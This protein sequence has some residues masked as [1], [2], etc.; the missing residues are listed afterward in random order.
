MTNTELLL[1]SGVLAVLILWN[2]FAGLCLTISSV[3]IVESLPAV[4]LPSSFTSLLGL[5][6]LLSC[7]GGALV[8]RWAFFLPRDRT[9]AWILAFGAAS[10]A[11]LAL[12]AK[13]NPLQP[14]YTYAQMV[15]LVWLTG[16]LADTRRRIEV[17]MIVWILTLVVTQ[18]IGLAGFDF[19]VLGRGNRLAS[20][21]HNPNELAFYSITGLCFVLYFLL[22][23]RGTLSRALLIAAF[24]LGLLSVLLSASRGGFLVLVTVM[25]FALL[26]L[27]SELARGLRIGGALLLF[28]AAFLLASNLNL[29]FVSSLAREIPRTIVQ[30]AAGKSSEVR[31]DLFRN[32]MRAWAKRPVLGVGLGVGAEVGAYSGSPSATT[33][34]H[35]TYLSVLVETG[36][37]GF[38]LFFGLLLATWLNLSQGPPPREASGRR[39]VELGWV[40]RAVLLS[41]L[42]MSL[43]GNLL[44]NKVLWVSIG[45][46]ILLRRRPD[47]LTGPA[48][49]KE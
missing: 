8:R 43:S 31:A 16:Q 15:I 21:A 5:L 12:A 37:V 23:S 24:V 14:I 4:H 2:P 49:E 46:S 9:Y 29:S 26:S 36:A 20:L 27:R 3:P 6:T 41:F 32:G 19:S 35:S 7:L 17:L 28:L 18:A 44:F 33:A 42:M 48:P 40:W 34:S 38:V 25:L 1:L 22:N 10:L 30:F 39:R 45:V 13:G 47:I 11:S